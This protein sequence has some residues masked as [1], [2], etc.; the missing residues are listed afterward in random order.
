MLWCRMNDVTPV[1]IS[2]LEGI[3]SGTVI[4]DPERPGV[5]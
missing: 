4:C 5:M 2:V 1:R 3:R